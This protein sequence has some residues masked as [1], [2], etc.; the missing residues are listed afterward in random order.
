MWLPDVDPSREAELWA[1]SGALA[2]TGYPD[3]PPRSAPGAPA[4]VVR[5]A[6]DVIARAYPE[7]SL[8]GVEVLGQRAA[9]AGFGRNAPWSCGGAFRVLPTMDGW[10]GL[11]LSRDS[12]VELLPALVEGEVDEPWPTV[13]QWLMGTT[14]AAAAERVVL[15]GLPGGPVPREPLPPRRDPI[16]ATPGGARRPDAAPL[17]VDLTS[18][19]AGPLCGALLVRTGA[20]VIKVESAA[21]PDGAR[22]GPAAFFDVLNGAKESLVL[23]FADPAQLRQLRELVASADVVL[24]ASRPR[25]LRQLGIDAESVV[26]QG[27][28]WLS[29][30]A[31]GRV[32]DDAMRVGFGDDIAAAAGL[33]G[34]DED[35]PFPVG[36]ALADPLSGVVGAAAVVRALQRT[37]GVLLDL[38]MHDL[39][40]WTAGVPRTDR[41]GMLSDRRGGS[42]AG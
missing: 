28:I 38:S 21:R 3:G 6:L 2:L 17:V 5:A 40:A 9:F 8:P 26:A 13:A 37:S 27:G 22:G 19:W 12:D 4:G 32:G 34:W 15:L 42:S 29:I 25:A 1:A 23:D 24:E 35:G 39:A 30:T 16:L 14:C 36:D 20:H 10:F 18:L 41:R 33:V 31:Y 7:A 11:S